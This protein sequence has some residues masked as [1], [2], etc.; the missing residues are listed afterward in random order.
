MSNN[1]SNQLK[2]LQ[3]KQLLLT[4]LFLFSF[5]VFAQQNDVWVNGYTRKD[6]THVQ[7]HYRTSPNR[8]I[9][10]NYTTKGNVNPYTGKPGYIPRQGNSNTNMSKAP[11]TNYNTY[12]VT[13]P[14]PRR[15]TN[16]YKNNYYKPSPKPATNRKSTPQNNYYIY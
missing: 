4:F 2:F 9:N 13:P 16:T 3:M 15:S 1:N 6:G 5:T 12:Q 8:T 7:G 14:T 11:K 10:D